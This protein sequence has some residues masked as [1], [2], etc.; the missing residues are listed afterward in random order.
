MI[1]KNI[2]YKVFEDILITN[3][4][5][6]SYHKISNFY[7][8]KP[9]PSYSVN[10]DKSSI[11]ELGDKNLIA[12]Q[13]K[14]IIGFNKKV[15]EVG[16]GTSQLSNYLAIGNNNKITALDS[17]LNSLLLGKNFSK[18]ND[19]HNIQYVQG[20]LTTK[21]FQEETFDYIWC[22]GV[23]HHTR[24]PRLGFCEIIKTLKKDGFVLLGLYNKYGR[25]RTVFRR[26]VYKYISKKLI[27]IMDPILRT[28]YK[29]KDLNEDKIKAWIQDQYEH[30]IESLHT[31]DEVLRWF[32]EENI[33]FI[34]SIPHCVNEDLLNTSSNNYFL[35][36][37][38]GNFVSRLYAQFMMLF[39]S[40]GSEGGLYIF[41]GKKK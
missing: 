14:K 38:E 34:N 41:V 26:F 7:N 6:E 19:I 17:A 13:F 11:L 24:D 12:K 3:S 28:L 40:L 39:S 9:F 33:D 30:P 25:F 4:D 29:N 36:T 8:K 1:D 23:L 37:D 18:K 15:L 20:D 35:K 32:R 5:D 31:F 22:N 10:D 21:I 2:N 27:P 16:S